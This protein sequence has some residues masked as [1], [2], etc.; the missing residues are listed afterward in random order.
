MMFGAL[1]LK[2]LYSGLFS[3]P[4]NH[5]L[6]VPSSDVSFEP[7][8]LPRARYS[9]ST[10]VPAPRKVI[11]PAPPPPIKPRDLEDLR[12]KYVKK[13]NTIFDTLTERFQ[14]LDK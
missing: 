3:C 13:I 2:V 10:P 9:T 5:L 14:Q 7:V 11:A 4:V 8:P 1:Q 6:A 12:T